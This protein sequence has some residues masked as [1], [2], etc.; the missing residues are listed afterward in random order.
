MTIYGVS[1]L[2]VCFLTGKLL[3]S[4]LGQ[5]VNVNGDV[6]GVGFAMILLIL[7]NAYL[8]KKK[9][10]QPA[11]TNGIT[12]WSSMYIPVVVA[13]AA[14]LNAKAALSGG[15]TALFIGIVVTLGAFFIVPL[16]AKRGRTI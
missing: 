15:Y 5:I 16:I 9:S 8:K 10:L 6:G 7:S 13:M 12:F 4:L 3:G 14:T 1:I 11:T 2:A